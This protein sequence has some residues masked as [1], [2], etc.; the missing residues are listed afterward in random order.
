VVP[1]LSDSY[2]TGETNDEALAD[3][4]SSIDNEELRNKF[5]TKLIELKVDTII[6][7]G[8]IK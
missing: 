7:V 1:L 2:F 8:K 4:L 6:E 5:K 3:V